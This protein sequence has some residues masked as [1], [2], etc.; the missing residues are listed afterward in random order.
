MIDS[1]RWILAVIAL[2][3]GFLIGEIAG[4]IIRA[5]LSRDERSAEIREM[6]RPV[7]RFVFWISAAAG[8]L[9]AVASTS[10]HAF[11]Q[12]PE[13]TGALLPNAL[14]AGLILIG[15]YAVA[16]AGS[17]A[18]AQST[19]RA[20]G[21]RHRTL[22]RAVRFATFGAACVLALSQMGVET[23][24]LSLALAVAVGVPALTVGLLTA[25]GS[26]GVAEEIAAGRA[27]RGHVKVG[28]RLE[29]ADAAGRV[30]HLHPVSV[31]LETDDGRHVHV[32]YRHLL[33]DAY[34]VSPV[35]STR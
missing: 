20:S 15:G 32:P 13:R 2:A 26:R 12:I 1:N 22:E 11:D 24:L 33:A 18:V 7:S 10:R 35:R 29:C 5:S 28:Y 31:E 23:R 17:A 3:S 6:A 9:I 14:L 34:S 21:T 19:V 8:F 30:V 4:R 27:L 25:L 16:I